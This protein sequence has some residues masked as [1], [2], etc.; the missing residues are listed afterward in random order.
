MIADMD[1]RWTYF[2]L[3][4]RIPERCRPDQWRTYQKTGRQAKWQ[5]F[6]SPKIVHARRLGRLQDYYE[7]LRC[8][9]EG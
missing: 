5:L 1:L 3:E 8:I 9:M 4:A 6:R 2:L 7:R